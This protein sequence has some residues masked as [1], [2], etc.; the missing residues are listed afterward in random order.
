M[1][2]VAKQRREDVRAKRNTAVFNEG[3]GEEPDRYGAP[4]VA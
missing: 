4:V 2:T 3:A 1:R